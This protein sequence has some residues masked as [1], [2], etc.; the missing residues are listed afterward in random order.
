LFLRGNIRAGRRRMLSSGEGTRTSQGTTESDRRES[1]PEFLDGWA[2]CSALDPPRARTVHNVV[3]ACV[4]AMLDGPAKAF[5][6]RWVA[7]FVAAVPDKPLVE[8]AM[9]KAAPHRRSDG[10]T[11]NRGHLVSPEKRP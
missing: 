8:E 10:P 9:R 1:E 11:L 2:G 3:H 6:A 5:I 4:E 7:S